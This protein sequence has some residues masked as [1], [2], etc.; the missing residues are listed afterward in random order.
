MAKRYDLL[1]P[2]ER[3]QEEKL[4]KIKNLKWSMDIILDYLRYKQ[5]S[6]E[7]ATVKSEGLY[8]LWCYIQWQLERINPNWLR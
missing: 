3:S 6:N 7:E 1:N 8:T 5:E 4:Q 2:Q